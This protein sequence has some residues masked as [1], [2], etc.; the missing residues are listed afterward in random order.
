MRTAL[1]EGTRSCARRHMGVKVRSDPIPRR[2][3]TRCVTQRR[4]R[5]TS[6]SAAA[7][8]ALVPA[9]PALP[10]RCP[11]TYSLRSATT[12]PHP[13]DRTAG[14]SPIFRAFFSGTGCYAASSWR[15]SAKLAWL[16]CTR[17]ALHLR[18]NRRSPA[19]HQTARR[20][21]VVTRRGGRVPVVPGPASHG[22][23]GRAQRG[24]EQ[25]R[26]PAVTGSVPKPG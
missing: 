15:P 12:S 17:P 18:P 4:A 5:L 26:P 13:R 14:R 22:N 21:P 8:C 20:S 11:A 24:R 6:H 7:C 1:L 9:T 10:I 19:D 25:P 23:R 3:M 2:A 16:G